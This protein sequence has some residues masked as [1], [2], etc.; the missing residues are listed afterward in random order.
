VSIRVSAASVKTSLESRFIDYSFTMSMHGKTMTASGV[1]VV[2]YFG[3]FIEFPHTILAVVKV[4]S[5][6]CVTI[7]SLRKIYAY[8]INTNDVNVTT[9]ANFMGHSV[10]EITRKIFTW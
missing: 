2:P 9:T 1:R 3:Y 6:Y 5:T 10:T 8:S 4:L 7:R